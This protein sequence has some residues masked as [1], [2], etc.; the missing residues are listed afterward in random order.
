MKTSSFFTDIFNIYSQI[1]IKKENREFYNLNNI[2]YYLAD[3]EKST[4]SAEDVWEIDIRSAFST[5]CRFLFVDETE[6]LK[7]LKEIESD[8]Q[9]RN[10]FISTS[11]KGTEY[12]KQLNLISKMV[13]S[14]TLMNADPNATIFELKKDGIIYSG[15]DIYRGE[16]FHKFTDMGFQI[17]RTKY[18]KYIRYQR[19]SYFLDND[20][21]LLI[22]GIFKDRPEFLFDIAQNILSNTDVDFDYLDKVYSSKFFSIIKRNRLDELFTKFYLCNGNKFINNI[23]RYEKIKPIS[24]IETIKP[25]NYLELFVYPLLENVC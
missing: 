1:K 16:L 23:F 21:S 9:R 3:K 2:V 15:D 19:T 10:V 22:K 14:S 24:H 7:K 8:K 20:D 12:L 11:L 25:K 17:R 4:I 18:K 5:I 6:F 13:I